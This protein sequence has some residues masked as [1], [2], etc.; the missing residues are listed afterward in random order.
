LLL[1]EILCKMKLS[2]GVVPN[3]GKDELVAVCN[4]CIAGLRR[5]NYRRPLSTPTYKTSFAAEM[6]SLIPLC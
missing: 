3:V 1:F 5:S 6:Q 2:P 4:N